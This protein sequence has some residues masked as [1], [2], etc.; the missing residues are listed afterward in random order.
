MQSDAPLDDN[1]EPVTTPA[2]SKK[3]GVNYEKI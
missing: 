1:K 2:E 3:G